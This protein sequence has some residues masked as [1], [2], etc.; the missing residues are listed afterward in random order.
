[1]DHKNSLM[2]WFFN[3][4]YF[5]KKI[6]DHSSN[7]FT[8]P[9]QA[10]STLVQQDIGPRYKQQVSRLNALQMHAQM[11]LLL[12]QKREKEQ[13][14]QQRQQELKTLSAISKT[15]HETVLIQQ[16]QPLHWFTHNPLQ[17][18]FE[19]I[20]APTISLYDYIE[21]LGFF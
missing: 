7:Q 12:I 21:R 6:T 17:H 10:P 3:H 11:Q 8:M 4:R 9:P 19:G 15:L 18:V 5:L 20:Q 14:E 13:Q 1:M 16:T 2:T